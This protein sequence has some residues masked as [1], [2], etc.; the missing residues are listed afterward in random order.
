MPGV[1]GKHIGLSGVC[2]WGRVSSMLLWLRYSFFE[3]L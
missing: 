1:V 3:S 2:C